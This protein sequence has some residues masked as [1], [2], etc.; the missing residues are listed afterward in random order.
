MDVG[1]FGL[2]TLDVVQAVL[3]H[4]GLERGLVLAPCAEGRAEAMHGALRA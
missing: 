1:E 2:L 4:F 3:K